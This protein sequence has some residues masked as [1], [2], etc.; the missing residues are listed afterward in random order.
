MFSATIDPGHGGKFPGAVGNGLREC[1]IT[2]NVGILLS[3]LLGRE[4]VPNWLT[5]KTDEHLA[6]GL[7]ED[8]QARCDVAKRSGCFISLHCNSHSTPGPNGIE[9]FTTPGDTGADLLA[10]HLFKSLQLAFPDSRFRAD[11]SDGDPD[12]EDNFYVLRHTRCPA[13]LVEMGFISNPEEA[14][15]LASR[16]TQV[17]MALALCSGVL[18]WKRAHM[19]IRADGTGSATAANIT[20][21]WKNHE[22]NVTQPS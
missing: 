4:G 13:V 19:A 14:A 7:T 1:D 6:D 12:K 21:R 9:V 17:Q 11:F 10:T 15:W 20:G 5:R 2:L 22:D 16:A 18:A 8:L 3:G